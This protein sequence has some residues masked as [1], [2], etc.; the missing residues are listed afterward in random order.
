[1]LWV[2]KE[3]WKFH[4]VEL[5]LD[6]TSITLWFGLGG[7]MMRTASIVLLHFRYWPMSKK[8]GDE[9]KCLNKTKAKMLAR[10]FKPQRRVGLSLVPFWP[11]Y[12]I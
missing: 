11:G 9:Q 10:H 2:W 3:L 1:M 5:I 8:C 4:K 7:N 12:L 6:E